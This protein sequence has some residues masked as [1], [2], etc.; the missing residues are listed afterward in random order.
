VDV[1]KPVFPD[2]LYVVNA[3]SGEDVKVEE[4]SGQYCPI[5]EKVRFKL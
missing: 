4:Y 5:G 1:T 2:D 3:F